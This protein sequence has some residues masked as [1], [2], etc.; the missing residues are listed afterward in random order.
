MIN[1]L[2]T[3][4]SFGLHDWFNYSMTCRNLIEKE[5]KRQSKDYILGVKEEDYITYLFSKYQLTPIELDITSRNVSESFKNGMEYTLTV[6]YM[7]TG[8]ADLFSV[9]PESC[10]LTSYPIRIDENT[11][12][13]Y[14]DV[15][16]RGRD[17]ELFKA[18]EAECFKRAFANVEYINV[19]ARKFNQQLRDIIT[20]FF[21]SRKTEIL[22]EN[23]FYKA[24]NLVIDDNTRT[25]FSVPTIKKIEI[26]IPVV[27][28]ENKYTHEPTITTE[29]YEDILKVIYETGKK[30]ERK[31]SLYKNKDEE[32]IRD[33]FLS[34]LETRYESTTA[35]GETFNKQGRTDILLKYTKDGSNLFIAECKFWSGAKG[36]EEAVNQLFE[37]YLTWRDSKVALIFFVS[38]KDFTKTIDTLTIEAKRHKYF[39]KALLAKGETSFS[40]VFSLPQDRDK[41][42]FLQIML[43]HFI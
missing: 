24:I 32:G 19:S 26:P 37:R 22:D 40:Y 5:I 42:V 16:V 23:I 9:R 31:P 8:T 6:S 2:H 11:R 18:K 15:T 13:I 27:S 33:Y 21:N 34:L 12:R 39:K 3:I 10:V 38:T 41:E 7:F 29:I 17:A 14:F 35:S 30:M 25:V 43:F 28:K 1:N 20:I 36:F 4:N